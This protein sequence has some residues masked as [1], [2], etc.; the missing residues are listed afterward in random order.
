MC[1]NAIARM[2]LPLNMSEYTI[3]N[4]MQIRKIQ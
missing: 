1:I 3:I 2:K 4:D